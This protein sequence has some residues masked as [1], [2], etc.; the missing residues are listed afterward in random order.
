MTLLRW[1]DI[2][3]AAVAGAASEVAFLDR[4]GGQSAMRAR[5][6]KIHDAACALA[7][8]AA[9]GPISDDVNQLQDEVQRLRSAYHDAIKQLRPDGKP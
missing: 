2:Y 3:L 4:N 6:H 8:I 1:Q 5:A 7:N 9:G